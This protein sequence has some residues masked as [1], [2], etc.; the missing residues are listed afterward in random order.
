MALALAAGC[1]GTTSP[2]SQPSEEQ[3]SST[4]GA[5]ATPSATHAA[6]PS[7]SPPV[8]ARSD[9]VGLLPK[10]LGGAEMEVH[11]LDPLSDIA[12]RWD[13]GIAQRMALQLGVPTSELSLA[14]AT[15]T[16]DSADQLPPAWRVIAVTYPGGDPTQAVGGYLAA[17]TIRPGSEVRLSPSFTGTE[18]RN[19]LI[20]SDWALGWTDEAI[21]LVDFDLDASIEVFKDGQATSPYPDEAMQLTAEAML[22]A[23]PA[24]TTRPRPSYAPNDPT[25]PTPP[26]EPALEAVMPK[27]VFGRLLTMYSFAHMR[28][29]DLSSYT[30]GLFSVLLPAFDASVDDASLAIAA[31]PAT[32]FSVWGNRLKGVSGERLLGGFIGAFVADYGSDLSFTGAQVDGRAFVLTPGWALY[33]RGDVL[34]WLVYYDVGDCYSDCETPDRPTLEEIASEAIRG[35]P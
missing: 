11:A 23:L 22:P 13:S 9:A 2:S 20:G 19:F 18:D 8:D 25:E 24:P 30:S 12:P 4:L 34:Y 5:T 14:V 26:P 33:A 17:V 16:P 6:T 28:E 7:A 31:D 29:Q 10:Q 35:I 27:S 15:P 1:V 3:P 32:T 21:Y